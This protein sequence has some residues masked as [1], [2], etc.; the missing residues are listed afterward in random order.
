M[1]EVDEEDEGQDE[2]LL[3]EEVTIED[4]TDEKMKLLLNS[5]SKSGD[6]DNRKQFSAT[7]IE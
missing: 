6:L 3:I 2:D 4:T 5:G 1:P 7:V